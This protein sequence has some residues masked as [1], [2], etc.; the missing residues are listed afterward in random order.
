[1]PTFRICRELGN[2][3]IGA[4]FNCL[5][6]SSAL[7]LDCS[8][9]IVEQ[10]HCLSVL[11]GACPLALLWVALL[12]LALLWVALMRLAVSLRGLIALGG[13]GSGW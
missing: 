4:S 7:P 5:D 9:V 6:G 8:D 13:S 1:M 11:G 12:R 2:S 10:R 3:S